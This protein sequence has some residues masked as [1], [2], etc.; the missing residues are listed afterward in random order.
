LSWFD[1]LIDITA[2]EA[3]LDSYLLTEASY[4]L[5]DLEAETENLKQ[6]ETGYEQKTEL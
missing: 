3:I 6:E 4:F 2:G 1:A 5:E